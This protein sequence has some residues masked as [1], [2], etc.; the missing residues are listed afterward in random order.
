MRDKINPARRHFFHVVSALAG[1]AV[2][3][4]SRQAQAQDRGSSTDISRWRDGGK[5]M[6][7]GTRILTSRGPERIE[8]LSIGDGVM[9]SRGEAKPIKWIGYR[10]YTQGA[11]AHWPDSVHPVRVARSALADN[12]P[13][14]DLYL[15]PMHALFIDGMLIPVKYLV[16]GSSISFAIPE[17]TTNIEYR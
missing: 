2:L 1:A 4:A 6:L 9:N 11:T 17:G 5:C 10:R 16:N 13:H 7:L 14:T 3:T 12:V 15:S 8:N